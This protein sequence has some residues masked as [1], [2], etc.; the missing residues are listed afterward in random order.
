MRDYLLASPCALQ[1]G[2]HI[3]AFMEAVSAWSLEKGELLQIVNE[4]PETV[5]EL[6][7]IVEEMDTRFDES[8]QAEILATI[9]RHLPPK[10]REDGAAIP[11]ADVDMAV[12]AASGG[13]KAQ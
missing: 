8:V 9:K 6:D 7:C 11:A 12:V 4:R 5:A 10:P 2:E 13:A 3:A 1:T